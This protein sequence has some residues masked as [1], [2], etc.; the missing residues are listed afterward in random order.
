M[1]AVGT[2]CFSAFG[3]SG[4]Q[5][6]G[7]RPLQREKERLRHRNSF[8]SARQFGWQ[9]GVLRPIKDGGTLFF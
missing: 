7:V 5:A 1:E 9:H 2:V 6:S 4:R 3:A 8:V